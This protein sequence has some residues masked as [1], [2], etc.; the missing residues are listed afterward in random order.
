MDREIQC[1]HLSSS[2]VNFVA[3]FFFL[4]ENIDLIF[5]SRFC[6]FSIHE[7]ASWL[8]HF[9]SHRAMFNT[10]YESWAFIFVHGDNDL[11]ECITN[12]LEKLAPLQFR[13]KYIHSSHVNSTSRP[14]G[15]AAS[16]AVATAAGPTTS[17][18]RP[19]SLLPKR[20]NVRAWL[21]DRKTQI[22]ISPKDP[23][24]PSPSRSS[25][26]SSIAKSPSSSTNVPS[27]STSSK[28][29]HTTSQPSPSS[30]TSTAATTGAVPNVSIRRKL[31]SIPV[32]KRNQTVH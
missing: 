30:S 9:V 2:Q 16:T 13:L 12:Q 22:K 10:Y 24:G 3:F 14:T 17:N 32:A 18:Q 19:S 27:K 29:T 26:S 1:I 15:A 20:F 6:F 4:S 11:F 8:I 31:G 28:Q 23:H 5:F 21:R 7:L 25:S